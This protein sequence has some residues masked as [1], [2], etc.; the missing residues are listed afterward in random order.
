MGLFVIGLNH[1]ECPL[2]VPLRITRRDSASAIK[3]EVSNGT[4]ARLRGLEGLVFTGNRRKNQAG[5]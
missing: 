4:S 2:G 3:A 5:H 1:K